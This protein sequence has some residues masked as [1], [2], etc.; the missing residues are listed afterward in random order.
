[1]ATQSTL[2]LNGQCVRF[3]F[4]EIYF[5]SSRR[6]LFYGDS[7]LAFKWQYREIYFLLVGLKML[8]P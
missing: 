5:K 3:I 7:F 6:L 1:M 2:F 4:Y 8:S